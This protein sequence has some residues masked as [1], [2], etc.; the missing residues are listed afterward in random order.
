[1]RMTLE[2]TESLLCFTVLF[3]QTEA[4]WH[5]IP[6][7]NRD[8]GSEK[9]QIQHLCAYRCAGKRVAGGQ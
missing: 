9:I 5:H 2:R 8:H 7:E 4:P 1:M 6:A 3:Q